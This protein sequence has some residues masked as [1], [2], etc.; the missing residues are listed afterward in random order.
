[1]DDEEFWANGV[2]AGPRLAG[3]SE[4]EVLAAYLAHPSFELHL[5]GGELVVLFANAGDDAQSY[6]C[7]RC[8]TELCMVEETRW[9]HR[10][11][12]SSRG[13]CTDPQPRALRPRTFS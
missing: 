9:R 13:G 3:S 12:F 5:V 11:S 6:V 2:S 10:R 4:L 1:M 7:G 8:G